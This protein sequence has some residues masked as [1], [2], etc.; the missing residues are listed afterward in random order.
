[1]IKIEDVKIQKRYKAE[2]AR[3]CALCIKITTT[4]SDWL[5]EKDI[6]PTSLFFSACKELGFEEV[7]DNATKGI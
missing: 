3:R 5:R 4:M 7:K 1:M 6:S 2:Y